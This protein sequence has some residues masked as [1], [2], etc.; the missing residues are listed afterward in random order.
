MKR[1]AGLAIGLTLLMPTLH[2]EADTFDRVAR[3]IDGDTS[4][5][6]DVTAPI[7]LTHALDK[8]NDALF[9]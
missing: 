6:I 5:S 8:L 4:V 2:W 3:T 7:D 1:L 9:D